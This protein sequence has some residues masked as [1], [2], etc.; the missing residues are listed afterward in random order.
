MSVPKSYSDS[1]STSLV[2]ITSYFLPR[3]LHY[4]M[5]E[6]QAILVLVIQ[7]LSLQLTLLGL[8][9]YVFSPTIAISVQ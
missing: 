8:S 4:T 6:W 5:W 7:T 2:Q 1:L 3:L 9:S